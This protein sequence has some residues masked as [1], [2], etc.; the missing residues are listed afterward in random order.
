MHLW[1]ALGTDLHWLNDTADG[2]VGAQASALLL[3]SS[4]QFR[5]ADTPDSKFAI[6]LI[7]HKSAALTMPG[8][9]CTLRHEGLCVHTPTKNTKNTSPRLLS[10]ALDFTM[11]N[12]NKMSKPSQEGSSRAD[13]SELRIPLCFSKPKTEEE[14][15]TMMRPG[16]Q[17]H[18]LRHCPIALFFPS[19]EAFSP[20]RPLQKLTSQTISFKALPLTPAGLLCNE[21]RITAFGLTS[22]Y[23]RTSPCLFHF[24]FLRLYTMK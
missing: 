10:P 19:G 1:H 13:F 21:L 24:S 12:Q 5:G 17:M 18:L 6:V 2:H 8:W 15:L 11:Q 7:R 9:N 3:A 14:V 4:D 23:N 20:Q 22:A 16:C